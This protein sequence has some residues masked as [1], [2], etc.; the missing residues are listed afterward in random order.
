M[1]ERATAHYADDEIDLRELLATLWRGKWVVILF[2]AVVAV[3]GVVFA[4]NQPNVYKSSVLLAPAQSE[5]SA[6]IIGGQLGGLASLAGINL[7]RGNTDKTVLARE[8][9]LSRAFLTD[10]IHRHNLSVPLIAGERWDIDGGQWVLD[11]SVF[12]TE[13]QSWRVNDQGE[14]LEPTDWDLV[15]AFREMLNVAEDKTTGM[16][17][18]SIKSLSPQMA[19]EVATELVRDINEHM[20]EEDIRDAE[21]RISYLESKLGET[22]IAG[23]QEVFYQLI[24]NETRT[25]MLAHAQQE[26]VFKT[27]DPA[28]IPQEPSEPNRALIAVVAAVLGGLLGIFAVFS[29]AFFRADKTPETAD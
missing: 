1:S 14:S 2:T 22:S 29:F 21:S 4:I 9:L 8:V 13:T 5:G 24:E 16:V 12:D 7:N 6:P 3:A 10:F 20:R 11:R 15:N 25:V 26:Y 23:M 28:V 18:L 27:I 19:K 17:T